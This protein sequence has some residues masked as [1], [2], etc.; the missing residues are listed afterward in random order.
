MKKL[1]VVLLALA[2]L[3]G[4]EKDH[5]T[6]YTVRRLVSFE[7]AN[8]DGSQKRV[9]TYKYYEDGYSVES[10]LDGVVTGL[11]RYSDVG[12]SL[13][14]TTSKPVDGTL[15]LFST[16]VTTYLNEYRN[17]I[18]SVETVYADGSPTRLESYV[19]ESTVCT[20]TVTEGGVPVSQR[21]ISSLY[22]G[23]SISM[24]DYDAEADE[25]VYAGREDFVYSDYLSNTLISHS[26][27]NAED[28]LQEADL[29]SYDEESTTVITY[30]K[31]IPT[32]KTVYVSSGVRI[33]FQRYKAEGSSWTTTS[34]GSYLYE[35][36]TY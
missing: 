5:E 17:D 28:I 31:E 13:V 7:E 14:V 4:C 25:W 3:V 21:E 18:S 27:Y 16:A 26:T 23:T 15:Q 9:D 1:F 20:I 22:N 19:Y 6:H 29:Y 12:D 34:N 11:V 36:V 35:Y 2:T 10:T 33:V 32:L 24:Y 8:A 30:V